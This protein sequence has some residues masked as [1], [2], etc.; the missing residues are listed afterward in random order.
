[1]KKQMLLSFLAGLVVPLVLA[2]AFQKTPPAE[3]VESE[4]IAPAQLQPSWDSGQV[5]TV[6]NRSGN[7]QQ[8]TLEA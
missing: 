2:A 1:M 4:S 7:L 5:L 6:K 8:M 3:D